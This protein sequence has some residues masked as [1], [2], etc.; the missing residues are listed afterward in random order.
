M[1][2]LKTYNLRNL[3]AIILFLISGCK[4]IIQDPITSKKQILF[5]KSDRNKFDSIY[6]ISNQ[7]NNN[8]YPYNNLVNVNQISDSINKKLK[9]LYNIQPPYFIKETKINKAND[10]IYFRI[11]K[12]KREFSLNFNFKYECIKYNESVFLY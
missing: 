6:D 5:N 4:I 2:R 10:F 11:K 3:I 1:D 12:G 9:F 8:F 7:I